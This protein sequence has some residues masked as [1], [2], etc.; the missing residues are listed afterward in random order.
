MQSQHLLMANY[1]Y[2]LVTLSFVIAI[3]AAFATLDLVRPV[4]ST[5]G[6]TRLAWL[7]GGAAAMGTGIWA[8]HYIGML[9]Y[10]LPVPVY[11][12]IP[13][14]FVSLLAAIGAAFVA[15]W[16]VGRKQATALQV[17]LG[18]VLMAV[19]IGTMHFTG[20]AAMRL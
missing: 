13:T 12:Q 10:K 20:M 1:D 19:G 14:V 8:M 6:R 2:R 15:L 3:G 4:V 9:A 11:Y 5:T 16:V 17:V 7:L 18:G